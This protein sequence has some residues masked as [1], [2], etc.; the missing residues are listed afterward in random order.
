MDNH[1]WPPS[2]PR[3]YYSPQYLDILKDRIA[4]DTAFEKAWNDLLHRADRLV[5][6]ELVPKKYAESGAGQHGNYGR[7]SNQVADMG[8]TLGLAYQMTC[9]QKYAQKL[10]QALLHFGQLD[11]W[12]GDA[13]HDPPWHS[14]LNTARFLFGYAVGY[15]SLHDFLSQSDRKAVVR[16]LVELGI[17]PTLHD[18]VLPEKRIHALDSMGHNWWSVC[19]GMAGVAALSVLGDDPRAGFWIESVRDGFAEWFTYQGNILQN[20]CLNF[21]S[22][23]AFYESVGY[24]NYALSEYLLFHL[25]HTSVFGTGSLPKV[26]LLESA[27]D[28]FIHTFY[29]T[30]EGFLATN[31]GDSS[32]H[33]S[34]SR[35][36]RLLLAAGFD[37]PEY[38]WYLTRTGSLLG[39]PIG[40]ATYSLQE[41]SEPPADLPKSM[42]YEDIGWA[43]MRSSWRDDA[44][45]LAVKSGFAW[46]HAHPDAGSF[47]LF[48][49]GKPL[50]I[51][52]GNCS[53]SRS[54]YTSYY[55]Q[56]RAH[57]V[58]L[59][60]GEAENPEACG[61]PDRG[62]VH[63]GQ[64][65]YPMDLAGIRYV[66]A[67]ATGP[68]SWKFSRNYRSFLWIDDVILIFDD[69][70]TH[71]AG[72]LEW[73]LHY[74]GQAHQDGSDI[75][76]SN[77]AHARAIVRPLYPR[78]MN[79]VKKKG[80]KDHDPDTEVDYLALVPSEN[81]REMKFITAVLP[82]DRGAEEP[83]TRVELLEGD[84][85]LG[86]RIFTNQE[87]TEVFLNLR[88]DGRK[89]HRNSSKVI[90][91]WDTDAYLFGITRPI[92]STNG[93]QPI[94]RCF[95]VCGSYLRRD[96]KILFDSLSKAYSV[97]RHD[98]QTL[99]VT[100]QG[101]PIVD[102]RI[103]AETR[104]TMV[105]L[106]ASVVTP[107]W[108]EN[109]QTVKL[110]LGQ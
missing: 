99:D 41:C 101:Q 27:G 52:S 4:S 79:T 105:R 12:A 63:T 2:H 66:L 15:D 94:S 85:M 82:L 42:V 38:H 69:I 21:D 86:V 53:Y 14:E 28:F 108:D 92:G 31:F 46:N 80:L 110:Q 67:N 98:G 51:D 89:M 102:C 73:L 84:E 18:W 76:L 9:E 77:D 47:I 96:G 60:D 16:A 59:I 32:I 11:R 1:N 43:M 29:P 87:I 57:N 24:A 26:P 75:H 58:V 103:G 71:E 19:V 68:T 35:T 8:T 97:I 65:C 56:S 33:A 49:G 91:G 78:N 44:T 54:E 72:Q 25:A 70:R 48:H 81:A 20:K 7:P 90:H 74:E 36:L 55:R 13:R 17:L 62:V 64:V 83:V 10:Q 107:H 93:R 5:D 109:R 100:L 104:P 30:S 45:M 23:G 50:I 39:D 106:N 95:I 22:K 40:L 61:G 34:G 3:L 88:A 37:H 6:A